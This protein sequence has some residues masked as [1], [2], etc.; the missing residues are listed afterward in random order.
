MNRKEEIKVKEERVRELLDFLSLDGIIFKKQSNFSWFT[1]GS[2]NMVPVI[3]ELGFTTI[4]VTRK[5][6]YLISN[7]VESARNME[8]EKLQDFDFNLLEYEW[9]ESK[10]YDFIKKIVPSLNVGCDMSVY[11][12]RNIEPQVKEIRYS[13]TPSEIER[14]LW[15]GEKTSNA[16]ETVLMEIK[17][18]QIEAEIAGELAR[19]LWKHRIDPVGY[20][21]AA[22]ERVYKYRH[23]I[24]TEKKIEKYLMLCVMARKWGLITTVTRLLNFGVLSEKVKKQYRDNVYIECAMI[25][26]TRPGEK[27]SKIFKRACDLYEEL[28]YHDEWKL[29]HQGGAMGYDVR[30]YI[31]SSESEEV[32]QQNQVFCWNPSIS[33]TKS[34]DGFIA[35]KDGFKFIT[36]PVLFPKIEVKVDGITFQR[37]A[38]LER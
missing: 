24:P 22:D 33:G 32:V 23:P 3:T 10:E 36:K 31:C 12:F 37:S 5:E 14:Y 28:G 19:L 29:H 18:G 4:L 27:T 9:F 30:D 1:G 26:A 25:A 16:I 34:E 21:A 8:E 38:I 7:R 2:I 35:M 17:P 20:Q 11:S 13:L 15:L 6:R